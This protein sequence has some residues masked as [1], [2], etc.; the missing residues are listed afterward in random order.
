LLLVTFAINWFN[1]AAITNDRQ[2]SLSL[3]CHPLSL[4]RLSLLRVCV[5]RIYRLK[6]AQR[7]RRRQRNSF[8]SPLARLASPLFRRIRK[9]HHLCSRYNRLCLY[10]Y[11]KRERKRERVDV[12]QEVN[13]CIQNRLGNKQ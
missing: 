5:R 3:G 6:R 1:Q 2:F 13:K 10:V 4:N 8:F 12:H 9:T 7:F 11:I